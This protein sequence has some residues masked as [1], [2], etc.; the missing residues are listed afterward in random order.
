[1]VV[2]EDAARFAATL[3]HARVA[4]LPGGGHDLHRAFPEAF[5]ALVVPFL[6]YPERYV[7]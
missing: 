2:P 5:L 6:D 7:E 4:R 3:R 1:M